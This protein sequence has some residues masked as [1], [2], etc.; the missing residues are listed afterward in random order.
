MQDKQVKV[1]IEKEDF[2]K[3]G[4]VN[5]IESKLK[6]VS[7]DNRIQQIFQDTHEASELLKVG[8]DEKKAL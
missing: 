2:I 8:V 7:E 4:V 6:G 5:K 3:D 1:Q